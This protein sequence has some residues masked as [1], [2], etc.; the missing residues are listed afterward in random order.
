MFAAVEVHS[1]LITESQPYTISQYWWIFQCPF[2]ARTLEPYNLTY[3]MHVALDISYVWN[4]HL[5]VII[6]FWQLCI[7]DWKCTVSEITSS[8]FKGLLW[9]RRYDWLYLVSRASH[10]GQSWLDWPIHYDS[11]S[12]L[13]AFSLY[14]HL[15][16]CIYIIIYIMFVLEYIYSMNAGRYRICS[17]Y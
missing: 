13:R 11:W 9:C 16:I 4:T 5:G 15:S 12:K 3:A 8:L 2:Y 6:G 7:F 17:N 14:K 10:W 1:S